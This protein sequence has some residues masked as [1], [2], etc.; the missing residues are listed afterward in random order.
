MTK[1]WV[2]GVGIILLFLIGLAA[3]QPLNQ[4]QVGGTAV[5][6]GNGTSGAGS[7]RVN[8]ASDNSAIANWGQGATG[9]APP[10]GAEFTG[11]IASGATGGLLQ[12]LTIC[13]Q[14]VD[15]NVTASAQLITGVSGRKVYFCSGNIQMNGG[16]NTVAFVSGTGTT[17]ATGTT[18]IPGFQGSTTAANGYSYA[19]NSGQS[20]GGGITPFARSTN[21]ADNICI[22]VGSATRVV[23]G[24]NYAIY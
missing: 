8:L 13:D 1:A 9:S 24:L 20:F 19:A 4:A 11:G 21:N 14:W 12:G 18:T 10:S 3:Q 22:L 15:I 23:G 7:A 2:A 16:A 17:C 6:T 5:S